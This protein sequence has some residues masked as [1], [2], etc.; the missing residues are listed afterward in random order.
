M[1]V[2]SLV[3]AILSLPGFGCCCPFGLAMAALAV[4]F[5]HVARGQIRR[6]QGALEGDGMAVAGLIIGY[7]SVG[8]Q[9]LMT[10]IMFLWAIASATIQQHHMRPPRWWTHPAP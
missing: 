5:G 4:I 10:I 8:L 2:A 3:L 9:V 7:I 1:A 6:S